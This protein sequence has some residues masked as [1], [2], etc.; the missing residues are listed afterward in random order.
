MIGRRLQLVALIADCV[1]EKMQDKIPMFI[2]P[3]RLGLRSLGLK[4][5]DA[6]VGS[7]IS[8]RY[9]DTQRACR[10]QHCQCFEASH[11][12]RILS[13]AR[14]GASGF[15]REHYTELGLAADH[16][17]ESLISPARLADLRDLHSHG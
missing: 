8:F 12:P 7:P 3:S 5:F 14:R 6:S 15:H 2:L 11:W 9:E 10:G 13:G 4:K 16:A 17:F 1:L